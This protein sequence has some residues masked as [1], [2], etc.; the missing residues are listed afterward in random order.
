MMKAS[1]QNILEIIGSLAESERVIARL[2]RCFA[3]TWKEDE[4][5]W[6]YLA[7]VSLVKQVVTETQFHKNAIEKRLRE[8]IG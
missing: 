2:Y 8:C 7:Y 3:E 6:L 5:F 4:S 1:L